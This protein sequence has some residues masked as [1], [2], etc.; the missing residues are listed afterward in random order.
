MTHNTYEWAG[1]IVIKMDATI[2]ILCGRYSMLI[3]VDRC[4]WASWID[5]AVET[6][7]LHKN[8]TYV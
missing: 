5:L 2:N 8:L 4:G 3:G 7:L 1:G 6:G